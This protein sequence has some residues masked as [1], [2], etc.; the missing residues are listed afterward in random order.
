MKKGNSLWIITI[1][2]FA[3]CTN[4][5][6]ESPVKSI[7]I[8]YTALS[9]TTLFRITCE[10]FDKYFPDATVKNIAQK[11]RIDS[12][13]NILANMQST[14]SDNEPDIRGRIFLKHE[15]STVD[16]VCLGTEFLR[17]KGGTYETPPE[18]V[19]MVQE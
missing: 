3:A 15:N 2:L 17:Y 12:M 8:K 13:V 4:K 14:D 5:P 11:T 1:L 19:N 10:T 7:T 16:T 18:L 6:A 9:H